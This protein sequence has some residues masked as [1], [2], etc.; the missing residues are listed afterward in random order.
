MEMKE[1]REEGREIEGRGLKVLGEQEVRLAVAVS[2]TFTIGRNKRKKGSSKA[3][4]HNKKCKT[5]TK[6]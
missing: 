2:K 3:C 5:N 1:E 6:P 4:K